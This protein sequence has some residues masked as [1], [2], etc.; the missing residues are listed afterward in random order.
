PYFVWS[1][2]GVSARSLPPHCHIA[3]RGCPP[4]HL[5]GHVRGLAGSLQMR[6][7]R[8][9]LLLYQKASSAF[10]I[11][12]SSGSPQPLDRATKACYNGRGGGTSARPVRPR[13]AR[14]DSAAGAGIGSA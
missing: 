4:P 13:R 14:K 8:T 12:V 7:P 6:A 11:G 2:A 3:A 5:F 9:D 10:P 1:L